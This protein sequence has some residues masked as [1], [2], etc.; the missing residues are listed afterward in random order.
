MFDLYS[1]YRSKE[2]RKLLEQL[3]I[4]RLTDKNEILCEYCNKPIVRAYDLIGHHKTELTEEN[5]N[6]YSIS[7]NPDNIAFV[8]HRCHNYIHDKLGHR[9]KGVFIVYGAPCSGKRAFVDANKSDGDLV[10]D[11]DSIWQA[12]SGCNR[13]IKPPKL[14]AVAFKIRDTLIEAVK[15]RLGKWDN[16]YII[17]GYPLQSERE[18]LSKELSAKEIYIE[19]TE[20]ECLQRLADD[21]ERKDLTEYAGYISDWF[22]QYTPPHNGQN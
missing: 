15:Y 4:E 12:V 17:G 8:H 5:V 21:D 14:K 10:I 20:E 13:Y 7:L 11:M 9:M 3:K 2:W 22:R 1:F 6:D 19:A 18:R 16:A